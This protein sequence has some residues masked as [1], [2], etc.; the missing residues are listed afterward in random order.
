M[1][2]T[3]KLLWL[4]GIL[5]LLFRVP[6]ALACSV[7]NIYVSPTGSDSNDGSIG[8]PFLTIAHAISVAVPGT[9]IN[10]NNGAWV[11]NA[12]FSGVSGTTGAGCNITLRS[13]SGQIGHLKTVYLNNANYITI[14]PNLDIS[15][16]TGTQ[17]PYGYGVHLDGTSNH[18]TVTGNYI[19]ELCHD[20]IFEEAVGGYNLISGNTIYK[21]EMSGITVNGNVGGAAG[22]GTTVIDN[23]VSQT[24]MRPDLL[25]GIYV[26]CGSSGTDADFIRV[27][28]GGHV[29]GTPG[30]G[31]YLHDIPHNT[32]AN[33]LGASE[34]HTDCVQ[35]FSATLTNT[36]I[37]SNT[38][39]EPDTAAWTAWNTEVSDL[40]G[41]LV[42]SVTYRN[43]V[44]A[45]LR[46]GINLESNWSSIHVYS[47]TFDH[48][49]QEAIIFHQ[50]VDGAT[51]VE[52]NIFYDVG[53][54]T[55]GTIACS[56]STLPTYT[57]ND[58]YMRSGGVGSYCGSCTCPTSLSV[59]PGFTNS[60]DGTGL[61]ANYHLATG[62][63][64]AIL[65]TTIGSFSVDKDNVTRPGRR[66]RPRRPRH[67][68][69]R[70][71]RRRLHRA[72]M[73]RSNRRRASPVR[74]F[75]R[76]STNASTGR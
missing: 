9:V 56:T 66:R 45:N 60:G 67:L 46:Q 54:G 51:D 68:H 48:I 21:A 55:D 50:A 17:Y 1:T 58:A 29:I 76:P 40:D 22:T 39:R 33:P 15:N 47:N 28:G 70:R 6:A 16:Q 64:L 30:H 27:F 52:N 41:S 18:D 19:H 65:G 2:M 26:G 59:V 75:G 69:R 13:T 12:I 24:Q 4:V 43:N 23:D 73:R 42:S 11:E 20:G 25:G 71:R 57:T 37:D 7:A 62:S 14:G 61:G 32:T 8:S 3:R 53:A 10:L 72:A 49:A 34:P 63:G 74:S 31:N 44:F 36:V 5:I 38:C 35:T